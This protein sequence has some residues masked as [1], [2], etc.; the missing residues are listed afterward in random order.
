VAVIN[1][2]ERR[3]QLQRR[4]AG[5]GLLPEVQ[6]QAAAEARDQARQAEQD[7][8]RIERERIQAER[9]REQSAGSVRTTGPGLRVSNRSGRPLAGQPL[10]R[11]KNSA[12]RL[13]G[14]NARAGSTN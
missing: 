9:Q 13:S 2:R 1:Q 3:E 7:R 4:I 14:E 8:L 10:R 12:M 11:R 5:W 6:E